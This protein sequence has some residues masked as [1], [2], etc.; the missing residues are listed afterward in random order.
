MLRN[1]LEDYLNSINERDFDYPLTSLLQAM[2]FYDIH[3]THG[4]TEIGKDFIAK[5]NEQGVIYQY[6]IQSK[7]GNINQSELE[8]IQNQLLLA[9]ISGLSHPQFDRELPRRV[10]LV[11]TGRLTGNADKILQDFNYVL[12]TEYK[13][14]EIIFWG[15]DSLIPNL[16]EFGLTGIYQNTAKGL[17][18][19]AQFYLIYSKAIEGNLSERE[20]EEFSRLWLDESL[21][22][23]KRILRAALECEIIASKL[24]ENGFLYES[25]TI[26]LSLARVV[27][28]TTYETDDKF[29]IEIYNEIISEKIIPLC[30]LFFNQFN[31]D[32]EEAGKSLLQLCLKENSFPMIHYIVWCARVLEINSL[33]YFLSKEEIKQDEIIT[34]II[35]FINSEEGC[36][37]IPSDRYSVSLVWITLALI[38]S[39]K[40]DEAKKLVQKSLVWLCD[41]VE[42]G[43]GL[44]RYEADEYEQTATLIG[45]PFDFIKLAP[46]RC[47]FLATII[48]DLSAFIEDKQFYENVI[49][50]FEA[51]QIVYI[52]WHFPDTKAIFTIDSDEC[53]SYP[54]IP[55]QFSINSFEDFEYSEHIKYEPKSF[56]I[57]EKAGKE[58][59]ILLSLFL[60]DRY[61]PTVWN[62]II[63]NQ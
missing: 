50:D 10:I 1:V 44:A 27:M 17:S 56:Q 37:H 25:I 42:K 5:L 46:N 57:M 51:C 14:E 29:I 47:S 19:F 26:Y 60:K 4:N 43:F 30:E 38:K 6:A 24:I 13:K 22:Y 34:F 48:G 49:N 15:K 20:I 28:K 23:R 3:F 41:R 39:E 7:K 55:H 2:G 32:W 35:D 58:S 11:T 18:G 61:F 12:K 16:E 21:E 52:Y 62:Q 40:I 36:G 53:I 59:L 33:Y 31:L 45:Y 9:I 8:R 63:T 54:N